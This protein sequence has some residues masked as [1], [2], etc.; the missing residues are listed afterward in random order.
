MIYKIF[1]ILISIRAL[2]E[3]YYPWLTYPTSVACFELISVH[4]RIVPP[5]TVREQ[6]ERLWPKLM[7]PFE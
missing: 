3:E 5:N 1:I 4:L 7:E 2:A 6:C